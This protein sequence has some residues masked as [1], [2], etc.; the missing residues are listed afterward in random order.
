MKY[1]GFG[2]VHP[3]PDLG[4]HLH[5]VLLGILAICIAVG[6]FYRWCVALFC[7]GFLYVELLDAV[8][9]LNHYYWL[10]LTGALMV[11]L[12]LN[13]KWS[14]DAWRA[15]HST[16]TTVPVSVVWLLR[17]QLVAVYVFGGDRQA[18][19]RLALQRDATDDLAEPAWRLSGRRRVVATIMGG[20]RHELVRRGI[21]PDDNAVD[22]ARQNPTIR[23]SHLDRVPPHHMAAVPIPRHVSM[24]DDCLHV[25][26]LQTRLAS[27]RA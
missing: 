27:T 20:L 10:S 22:V 12:P 3:L 7:I 26:F 25:D 5:F 4:M 21:R 17:A 19:P 11:F 6:L 16:T 2:W 18:E 13:R 8:T 9:Y 15:G 23:I 1:L 24:A 14:L